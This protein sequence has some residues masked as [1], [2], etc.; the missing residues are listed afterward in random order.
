MTAAQPF[1]GVSKNALAGVLL[2]IG[3]DKLVSRKTRIDAVKG[4]LRDS[5]E[6]LR[7]IFPWRRLLPKT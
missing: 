6:W 4:V 3:I 1:V 7:G 5:N 2:Q